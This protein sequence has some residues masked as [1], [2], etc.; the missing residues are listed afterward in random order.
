MEQLLEGE[1]GF[2]AFYRREYGRLAGALRLISGD[3]STAEE[4]AQEAFVRVYEAWDRVAVMERP[5]AYLYT[6]AFNMARKGWKKRQLRPL[7]PPNLSRV[8]TPDAVPDRMAL[9]KALADL[10]EQQRKAVVA[11]Y[12]LGFSTDEAAQLLSTTPGAL[13]AVLHRAVAA[14]RLQPALLTGTEA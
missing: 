11:R 8:D 6:V 13:R 14:L 4:T 5:G 7:P 1:A 9:T 10:P 3:R 12:V 2:D